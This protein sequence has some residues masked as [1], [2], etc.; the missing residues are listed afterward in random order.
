MLCQ[1]CEDGVRTAAGR[2]K[3]ILESPNDQLANSGFYFNVE[4]ELHHNI[5]ELHNSIVIGCND[6]RINVQLLKDEIS[7]N[8]ELPLTRLSLEPQPDY[9]NAYVGDKGRRGGSTRYLMS[10]AELN[11][12]NDHAQSPPHES[13][14]STKSSKALWLK[15]YTTCKEHHPGCQPSTIQ[16]P[17]RPTRLIHVHEQDSGVWNLVE[18]TKSITEPYATLSHCWGDSQYETLTRENISRYKEKNS[19]TALP[20]TFRD[21]I[22]VAKSLGIYYI[23]IDSLCIIQQDQQDW[24]EQSVLMRKVY[25]HADC[26]IAA[27]WAR[28]GDEG[29]F[30]TSDAALKHPTLVDLG[31][32]IYGCSVYQFSPMRS[33][34]Y[35]SKHT[36]FIDNDLARAPLNS[37]AWVIQERYMAPRQLSFTASQVYWECSKLVANEQ[38]P[39]GLADE[40]WMATIS[41]WQRKLLPTSKADF[42]R[43]WTHLVEQYSSCGLTKKTDKVIALA[44]LAEHLE[45]TQSD[46]GN[47]YQHGL[48]RH[49]LY[50]QLCWRPNRMSQQIPK[51]M[52]RSIVPTWSWLSLDGQVHQDG[53]FVDHMQEDSFTTDFSISWIQVLEDAYTSE[54]QNSL[55]SLRGITMFGTL[56]DLNF[57]GGV[58]LKNV[59]Y[60]S[61]PLK[62]RS[63]GSLDLFHA[64]IDW[65]V[66]Q[67]PPES[68]Q[69]EKLCFFFVRFD[70]VNEWAYGLVLQQ[71][72][73]PRNRDEYVRLGTIRH[74]G[75]I[76]AMSTQRSDLMEHIAVLQ[77]LPVRT[78]TQPPH[79][80]DWPLDP[81]ILAQ[82]AKRKSWEMDLDRDGM[83]D[84]VRTV[85]IR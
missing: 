58:N 53:A 5:D 67:W 14:T 61:D 38:C 50:L 4:V 30:I 35:L 24:N 28:G 56:Q 23:W 65:S 3:K 85:H 16:G 71:I 33:N 17:F 20:K 12:L 36:C 2:L 42:R 82:R 13:P 31:C 41:L 29:C 68:P 15:W 54:S 25:T 1:I 69:P 76:H 8:G 51:Q 27:S 18:E 52:D 37:R 21:A 11:D 66:S 26:N 63:G 70:P 19:I 60:L 77:G 46:T 57:H 10:R 9:I 62:K 47:T 73:G 34:S 49:D 45:M 78:E 59:V 84:L 22:E 83:Q 74:V 48:W 80:R 32:Q 7:E 64:C 6:G 79:S 44:G 55:L 81:K 43:F 75:R 72:Q 40:Y 39:T